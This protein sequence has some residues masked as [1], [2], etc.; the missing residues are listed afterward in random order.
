MFAGIHNTSYFFGYA[1][2]SFRWKW[3]R[4]PES[5]ILDGHTGN[6]LWLILLYIQWSIPAH[7]FQAFRLQDLVD[8]LPC[9][10]KH[11]VI[12]TNLWNIQLSLNL[13]V[14]SCLFCI[15]LYVCIYVH[16][17]LIFMVNGFSEKSMHE[18]Q[19][20]FF[21]NYLLSAFDKFHM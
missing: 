18:I 9:E 21:R 13:T 2:Q 5:E 4:I 12:W 11:I 19:I 8:W 6:C 1:I 20:C 7:Q 17:P 10:Y 3:N 15:T 14:F 16:L